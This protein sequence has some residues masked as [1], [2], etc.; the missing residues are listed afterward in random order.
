M[1]A[2]FRLELHSPVVMLA[3]RFNKSR[4]PK[5]Q[6]LPLEAASAMRDYLTTKPTN[7][8]VW[9]GTW[10]TDHRGAEM[11]R[12][13]LEAAGIAY[14]IPGADGPEY[15]DF[16]ALRHSFLTLGGRAGID[17]RTLQELAG[18]SKPELT[19]RYSHRRLDDLAGAVVR[20]PNL[21]G[22]ADPSVSAVQADMSRSGNDPVC[23]QFARREG[24]P[25]QNV[26]IRRNEVRGPEHDARTSQP[27]ET[28]G[29]SRDLSVLEGVM[30][31]RG[32]RDSNPQ[33]PDRQVGGCKGVKSSKNAA[34]Q[35]LFVVS[36]A[37]SAIAPSGF[38]LAEL[39]QFV[40][41]SLT[42]SLTLR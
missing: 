2:D 14:S 3:A 37:S 12:G 36:G 9:D 19:A 42:S 10:A 16:H 28:Q 41:V 6:P 11:I 18:H 39:A 33:P 5:V 7:R 13:D 23:T 32:R 29:F 1:P 4:K 21:L 15:A 17:L 25:R 34:K 8:P 40:L 38:F 35:G 20:M 31:Q 22:V 24:S 27:Q 30:N 26:S